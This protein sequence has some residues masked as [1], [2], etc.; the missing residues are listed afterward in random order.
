MLF[1]VHLHCRTKIL[2]CCGEMYWLSLDIVSEAGKGSVCVAGTGH[3]W[4]SSSQW[5]ELKSCFPQS[6]M[7]TCDSRLEVFC[8]EPHQL[9]TLAEAKSELGF[10]LPG[11]RT[12]LV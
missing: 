6:E 12:D 10:V 3:G 4:C 9:T 11:L 2:A 1:I 5:P 8:G 7:L